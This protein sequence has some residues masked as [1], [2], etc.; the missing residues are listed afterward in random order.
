[1]EPKDTLD[2]FIIALMVLCGAGIILM[3]PGRFASLAMTVMM[4]I[5]LTLLAFFSLLGGV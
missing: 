4:A 5:S 3:S 2:L 1:M